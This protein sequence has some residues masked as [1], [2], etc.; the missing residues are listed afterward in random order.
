MA[1]RNEN[2]LRALIIP[3]LKQATDYVV[4]KIWNE[5]RSLIEE[6]VYNAQGQGYYGKASAYTQ[7][8]ELD[9]SYNRTG[10]FK[11]AWET[12][13]KTL[14]DY[15][16]GEFK[17][18]PRTLEV[19]YSEWQHGSDYLKEPMT[20]YLADIIYNGTAGHIFGEGYWT[21]KRDAWAA[22]DK[23]LTNR[24]FRQIFEEGMT[25]AGIPWKKNKGAVMVE[26]N[27]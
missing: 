11:E 9:K 1:V 5:N 15:V 2:E 8:P 21:K 14:G 27:K 25:K 18:D 20:T 10:Q 22:L 26:K 23:W 6:I 7:N 24:R 19:N 4:Q 12:D 13:V 3:A 16:E 17:Y